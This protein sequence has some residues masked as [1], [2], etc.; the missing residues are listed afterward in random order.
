MRS[1]VFVSLNVILLTM[2]MAL[3]VP[4]RVVGQTPPA[5]ALVNQRS[6]ETLEAARILAPLTT[7][8]I[9]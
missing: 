3:W 6:D 9:P 4:L 8:I 5:S 1:Q 7:L 2:V